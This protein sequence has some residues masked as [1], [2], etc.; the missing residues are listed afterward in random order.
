MKRVIDNQ[1][2]MGCSIL[3]VC[4][5]VFYVGLFIEASTVHWDTVLLLLLVTSS[6][7][8]V[9]QRAHTV[10]RA[11]VL[12]PLEISLTL[13]RESDTSTARCVAST[14]YNLTLHL[15]KI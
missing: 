14:S 12:G 9:L 15:H 6:Q 5:C 11:T 1:L 2:V 10:R 7:L 3:C 8:R 13:M 4:A